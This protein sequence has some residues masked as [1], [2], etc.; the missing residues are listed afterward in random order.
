MFNPLILELMDSALVLGFQD[1]GPNTNNK[2]ALK[3]NARNNP[4]ATLAIRLERIFLCHWLGMTK[5]ALSIIRAPANL[6]GIAKQIF[7]EYF[8]HCPVGITLKVT[9]CKI[10][11]RKPHI[12]ENVGI[13]T[14]VLTLY[15]MHPNYNKIA[16]NAA[17]SVIL[18]LL[19]LNFK[20]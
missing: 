8:G 15:L 18:V 6:D 20:E 14:I 16:L 9:D 5:E 4:L 19:P 13:C 2:W 7:W 10:G 1:P 12:I 17:W 11:W 3:P